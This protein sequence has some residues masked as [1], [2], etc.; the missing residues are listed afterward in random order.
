MD[1]NEKLIENDGPYITEDFDQMIIERANIRS[2]SVYSQKDR[3]SLT[4]K[5]SQ[6]AIDKGNDPIKIT[7]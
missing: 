7:W 3:L 5:N 1:L 2:E 6:I 4:K